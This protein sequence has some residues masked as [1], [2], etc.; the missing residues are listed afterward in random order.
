MNREVSGKNWSSSMRMV[1][2]S[3]SS[4][5]TWPQL[6]SQ[7]TSFFARKK[8]RTHTHTTSHVW[9]ITLYL[10]LGAIMNSTKRTWGC[11]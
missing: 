4:K 5:S 1:S 3:Q 2:S 6:T 7:L 11:V 8:E 9:E 10:R